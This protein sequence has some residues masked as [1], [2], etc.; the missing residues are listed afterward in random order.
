MGQ[1]TDA[2]ADGLSPRALDELTLEQVADRAAMTPRNVRAYQQRGL[3]PPV[4]RVGRRL[5]YRQEHVARL[6]LIRGL[7]EHGLSLK[8]IAD[9]IDRGTADHEL[10]R[11]GRQDL[12]AAWR[13]AVRVPLDPSAVA[14][15]EEH[16]P[17]TIEMMREAGLISCE[18]GRPH[19][20]AVGL[21]LVSALSARGV[22]LDKSTALGMM[23]ARAAALVVD[24]LRG[25][26]EALGEGRGDDETRQLMLQLVT[27]AFADVLATRLTT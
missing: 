26:L 23:G 19:S 8:V 7:H 13:M 27:T 5:V 18:G 11:L 15:Y 22:D 21:G 12:V 4:S 14:F 2:P 25:V 10:G 1:Q 16:R 6:R 3:L 20:S 24:D 9:L 17:G